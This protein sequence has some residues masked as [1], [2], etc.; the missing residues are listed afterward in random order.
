VESVIECQKGKFSHY[1]NRLNQT[2]WLTEPDFGF[3]RLNQARQFP[4]SMS[5]VIFRTIRTMLS[6]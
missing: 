6:G 2:A 4:K 5:H 1:P 3:P